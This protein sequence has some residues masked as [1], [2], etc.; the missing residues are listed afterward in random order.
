ML[1]PNHLQLHGFTSFYDV[2]AARRANYAKR[3]AMSNIKR[4]N[5]LQARVSPISSGNNPFYHHYALRMKYTTVICFVE[6]YRYFS[7][8]FI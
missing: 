8:K 2:N 6:K 3:E 7:S 5:V 1:H 4:Q